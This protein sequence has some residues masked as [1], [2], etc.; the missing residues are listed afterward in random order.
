MNGAD[1]GT[2]YEKTRSYLG[3][4]GQSPKHPKCCEYQTITAGKETPN[5]SNAFLM[6]AVLERENMKT[7]YKRV[8][9]N[10]G[11]AGVDGM[12]TE[13]L[14]SHLSKYWPQI[15]EELSEGRYKPKPVRMVE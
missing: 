11:S 8:R 13:D 1:A 14:G 10:G 3:T 4:V 15:K 6:E 5:Q 7:A 9:S 2:V 12:T